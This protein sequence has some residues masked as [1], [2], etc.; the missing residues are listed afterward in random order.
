MRPKIQIVLEEF[1]SLGISKPVINALSALGF[2][3][4]SEIQQKAIPYLLENDADMVGLAQTGTGKTAA[5]GIPLLEKIDTRSKNTQALILSPTRELGQQI[6]E[7]IELY[8]KNIKGLRTLAVYGGAPIDK[9][10]RSLRS[11]PQIVIATPGRLLDLLNRKAANLKN[12]DYLVLDEAD[13][14]LN[15]GFKEDIDKILKYTNNEKK[16]WLFSATMPN[17]IRRIISE[18]MDPNAFEVRINPRSTTNENIEHQYIVV[19]GRDKTDHF[20]QYL[21]AHDQMRSIVFCRTKAGTSKL[22]E[23]LQEFKIDAGAIHGDLSQNQRDR[24]MKKFK[25]HK[26]SI[27]CATDV[28]ARGI[29]VNDLTHVIHYNIPENPEYYTHRSGRTA[30]AGK[31]GISISFVTGADIRRLK[32]IQQKLKLKVKEVDLPKAADLAAKKV[33]RWATDLASLKISKKLDP[34]LLS[35][36]EELLSEISKEELIEKLVFKE[37]SILLNSSTSKTSR[38]SSSRSSREER[39]RSSRDDRSREKDWKRDKGSSR[40]KEGR[41]DR[42]EDKR[43]K[44]KSDNGPARFYINVGKDDDLSKG[45]LVDFISEMSH[46]PKRDID[47]VSVK[48]SSSYFEVPQDFAKKLPTYFKGIEIDGRKLRVNRDEEPNLDKK[49]DGYERPKRDRKDV[50]GFKKDARPS[51]R[52]RK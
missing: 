5:F 6:A 42:R 18:Y 10:L 23:K 12:I 24:V 2:E 44:S 43:V 1:I 39:P 49:K 15:M 13:E 22:A 48:K 52:R 35:K 7:Q 36:A 9:Q 34:N 3:K 19:P 14:M 38:A 41:T 46:L 27:L 37:I 25:D 28:A 51:K 21:E 4:P 47:N 20:V 17:D 33:D 8:G 40:D 26:L 30:R 31:K 32:Y 29:D 45:D 11:G 50:K 16:T